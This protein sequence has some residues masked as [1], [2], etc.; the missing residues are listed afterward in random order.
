MKQIIFLSVL[1]VSALSQAATDV[2]CS[3]YNSSQAQ[4]CL[5]KLALAM[6][7][8]EEPNDAFVTKNVKALAKLL[9]VFGASESEIQ[10][11][12]KA[13]YAGLIVEHGDEHHIYYFLIRKGTNLKPAE[14]YELNVVDLEYA[15][16]KPEAKEA[17]DPKTYLLG[18]KEAFEVDVFGDLEE[19][20]EELKSK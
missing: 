8:Y 6:P 19:Q 11:A 4:D 12:E 2:R 13:D 15:V 5:D 1:F 20:I 18:I 3:V 17:Q 9:K 16:D 14:V 7:D 10:Q